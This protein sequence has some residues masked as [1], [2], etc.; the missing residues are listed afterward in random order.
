MAF[1]PKTHCFNYLK[2]SIPVVLFSY[3]IYMYLFLF[4]T[5]LERL[6]YTQ[7]TGQHTPLKEPF[8]LLMNP[9]FIGRVTETDMQCNWYVTPEN[10]SRIVHVIAHVAYSKWA[11]LNC[12]SGFLEV[13]QPDS[14]R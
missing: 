13:P 9:G 7:C 14:S 11:T 1:I 3:F 5:F 8:G 4:H 6:V 12:S 2:C 10:A